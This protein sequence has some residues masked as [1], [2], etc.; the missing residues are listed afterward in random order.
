MKPETYYEKLKNKIN[1]F[2]Y[3][4]HKVTI[5]DSSNIYGYY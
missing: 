4:V 5:K 3:S 2:I 1:E